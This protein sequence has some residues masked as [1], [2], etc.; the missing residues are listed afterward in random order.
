MKTLKVKNEASR[1]LL[2]KI[3]AYSE[4]VR[5]VIDI[6][7]QQNNV[8]LQFRENLNPKTFQAPSIARKLRYKYECRGIDRLLEKIKESSS[9]FSELFRRAD[10]LGH[11]NVRLVET[12]QDDNSKA[13]FI[14]TLVTILFLPLTFVAGFFGMN[15]KG[16]DGSERDYWHFWTIALPMTAGIILICTLVTLKGEDAYFAIGR[17]SR[18]LKRSK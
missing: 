8:L 1:R 5:I 14:F 13:I 2:Q 11:E 12:L 10:Q 7:N 4:E 16:I 15:L 3:N 17:L 9:S 18:S 6:L